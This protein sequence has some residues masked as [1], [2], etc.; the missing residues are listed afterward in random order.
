MAAPAAVQ[1]SLFSVEADVS[2]IEL[3]N[4]PPKRRNSAPTGVIAVYVYAPLIVKVG[5]WMP[6]QELQGEGL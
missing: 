4:V 3:L 2:A 1:H 6:R 5:V